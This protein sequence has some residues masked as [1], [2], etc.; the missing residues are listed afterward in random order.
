MAGIVD[1]DQGTLNDTWPASQPNSGNLENTTPTGFTG[2]IRSDLYEVRPLTDAQGHPIVDPHTGTS[3][4]AYY[5]GYF[6]LTSAGALSFKREAASTAPPPPQILSLT[7]AGTSST[8]YFTTVSG[9]TY[10][11]FYTDAAGLTTPI[12][13]WNSSPTTIVGNGN[14][15]SL[16]DT[17]SDAVRFYR[18]GA[19]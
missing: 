7:R 16:T 1:P 6:E 19:R 18:V 2:S 14:T 17:T 13:S 8:I 3:G 12:T 10:T 5:V 11:L 4:L 15:G 9:A